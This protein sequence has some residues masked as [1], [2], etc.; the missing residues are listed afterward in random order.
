MFFNGFF[1]WLGVLLFVFCLFVV[2]VVCFSFLLG[3]LL[4]LGVFFW[5][6]F[7]EHVRST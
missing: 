1:G 2:V 4:L 5:C 6:F 7:T 3:F